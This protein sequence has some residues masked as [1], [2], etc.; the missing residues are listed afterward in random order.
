MN[1]PPVYSA[2]RPWPSPLRR[3]F[4]LIELLVV[5]AIIAI[6]AA[7]LLPAL[8]A[9]KEKA[10]RASCLSNLRQVGIAL[11]IYANDGS[12]YYP[13]GNP[14]DTGAQDDGCA[15]GGD[16]WDLE[17]G[18]AN[19]LIANAGQKRE[20]LYCPASYASKN[21]ATIQWWWNYN[22]SDA[23]HATTGDYKSLG[24]FFMIARNDLTGKIKNSKPNFSPNP[25]YP[26]MFVSKTS[27]LCNTNNNGLN[28]SST[29]LVTDVTLSDGPART[30]NFRGI[31]TSSAANI[32]YLVNGAYSSSHMKGAAV[33]GG[34][35]LFQDAHAEWR[36]FQQMN[37]VTPDS[38]SRY[39]WF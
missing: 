36:Q 18:Q 6:L 29:E 12:D 4:T 30:A 14:A 23:T 3:A 32:P 10:K 20:V 19:S 8:A 2:S 28:V 26:R 38:Q 1:C 5:I 21:A 16:L 37:W 25:A 15:A 7:M 27:S 39:Q 22:S 17:N 24:Y 34:D 35:I 31:A 13:L 33:A 11:N 9:A